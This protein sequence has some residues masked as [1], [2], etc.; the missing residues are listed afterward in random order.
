MFPQ[1]DLSTLTVILPPGV[2]TT[3]L[4]APGVRCL[5]GSLPAGQRSWAYVQPGSSR[6]TGGVR[7]RSCP[8][9]CSAQDSGHWVQWGTGTAVLSIH[10]CPATGLTPAQSPHRPGVSPCTQGRAA[11]AGVQLL[12]GPACATG[13]TP[14]TPGDQTGD[15]AASWGSGQMG[16]APPLRGGP[17]QGALTRPGAPPSLRPP[18]PNAHATS[19]GISNYPGKFS[20]RCR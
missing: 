8:L 13:V 3:E 2:C 9:P 7:T 12:R 1:K 10:T 4:E 6:A 20:S 15:D 5:G 17:V 11:R 18:H 16:L 14:L 19:M